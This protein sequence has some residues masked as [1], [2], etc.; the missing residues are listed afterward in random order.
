[1]PE[2]SA[3]VRFYGPHASDELNENLND[4]VDK[5]RLLVAIPQDDWSRIQ[6]FFDKF[7]L[8]FGQVLLERGERIRR[9][10]W[11]MTA[12]VSTVVVLRD[13][14]TAEVTM[15]GRTGFVGIEAL[16]GAERALSRRVVQI[17]GVAL[18]LS[19]ERFKQIEKQNHGFRQVLNSYAQ[20]YMGQV[21]QAAACN[22][23]HSVEERMAR[24]LLTLQDESGKD[25]L[26][27]TQEYCW[28]ARRQ[29]NGGR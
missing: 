10:Y 4:W 19:Y 20:A 14:R 29:P 21:F 6:E 26:P 12:V 16:F 13:G 5:N 8:P 24:F 7:E 22:S 23:L 2:M 28:L 27:I 25:R 17:P 15:I 1:M 11:P 18:A 3:N 9:I